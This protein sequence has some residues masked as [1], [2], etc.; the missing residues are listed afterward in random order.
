M[1]FL[2]H[3]GM[4]SCPLPTIQP[5]HPRHCQ[6]PRLCWKQRDLSPLQLCQ[7][8]P[9]PRSPTLK[10]LRHRR[11][12]RPQAMAPATP[13]RPPPPLQVPQPLPSPQVP[14]WPRPWAPPPPPQPQESP[15]VWQQ[16]SPPHSWMGPGLAPQV[17]PRGEARGRPHLGT[18]GAP[19][20]PLPQET[21]PLAPTSR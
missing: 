16:K 14:W 1:G 11:P 21:R 2:P 17:A 19:P 9:R 6:C 10:I 4:Q 18:P 8:L 15:F 13:P 7:C 20:P 3:L 5:C 12:H